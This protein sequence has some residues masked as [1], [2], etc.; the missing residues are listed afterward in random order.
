MIQVCTEAANAPGVELKFIEQALIYN[1]SNHI[2]VLLQNCRSVYQQIYHQLQRGN[3]NFKV[4]LIGPIISCKNVPLL[5]SG[6]A[7]Q[8]N[9]WSYE[10]SK[11]HYP[12]E[13]PIQT[14]Q[15]YAQLFLKS[16]QMPL[17]YKPITILLTNKR[18]TN[19]FSRHQ[20]KTLIQLII[21]L[22]VE[23]YGV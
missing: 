22:T 6:F 8:W 21:Q 14:N 1:R 23:I 3:R 9:S 18:P 17:L 4:R 10:M 13:W 11:T 2:L 20:F 15:H 16:P 12:T 19:A 7:P 5:I